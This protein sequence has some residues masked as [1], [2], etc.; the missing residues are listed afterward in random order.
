[1]S[2]KNKMKA[3]KKRNTTHKQLHDAKIRQFMVTD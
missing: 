2:R 1:M 3:K